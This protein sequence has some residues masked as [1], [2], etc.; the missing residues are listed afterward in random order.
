[1]TVIRL[2]CVGRGMGSGAYGAPWE[3]GAESRAQGTEG[4]ML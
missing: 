4:W 2:F 1:M 3:R